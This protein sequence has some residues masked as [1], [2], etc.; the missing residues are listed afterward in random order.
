MRH[1]QPELNLDEIKSQRILAKQIKPILDKY[2]QSKLNLAITPNISA[3]NISQS[4]RCIVA[5]DL[6]RSVM[7]AQALVGSPHVI[8]KNFRECG[9]PYFTLPLLK[10]SFFTWAI[11][12][13]LAW[14]C[15]YA[16][17]SRS[18]KEEKVRAKHCSDTLEKLAKTSGSVLHIGHGIMNRLLIKELKSRGWQMRES[19]GENYW[20][21]KVFEYQV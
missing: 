15:G 4:C 13:R 2:Q 21:Y 9:L 11:I 1:G 6:P 3:R 8:D 10:L 16:Q 14:L 12:F 17:N 7:S 5:S 20:S 19:T 18:Y